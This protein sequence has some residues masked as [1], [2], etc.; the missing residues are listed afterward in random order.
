MDET[1]IVTETNLED[2]VS[3]TKG[4]YVGQEIIIRIKHRGHVAKKLTGVV[5]ENQVVLESGA[6]LLSVEDKEIGRVTSST[7]SPRLGGRTVA[8]GYVK[9]DYLAPH[10]GVTVSATHDVVTGEIAELPLVRGSWYV[11]QF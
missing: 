9:Y 5:F 4:C 3:F 8:L 10:S 6:K 2:A 7:V 11:D 1:T